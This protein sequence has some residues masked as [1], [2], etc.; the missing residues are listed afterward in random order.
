MAD[1]PKSKPKAKSAAKAKGAKP[2]PAAGKTAKKAGKA[3]NGGKGAK[4]TK[5]S[6]PAPAKNYYVSFAIVPAEIHDAPPAG[7]EFIELP[8]FDEA[9]ERLL[10]HLIETIE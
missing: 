2:A 5:P 1:K 8:S 3:T 6:A 4:K 7:I 9:R 10:D